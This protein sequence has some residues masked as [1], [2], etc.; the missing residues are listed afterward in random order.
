MLCASG[1]FC[2][3]RAE[4]HVDKFVS[5]FFA[6]QPE[7]DAYRERVYPRAESGRVKVFTLI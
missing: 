3:E 4:V 6:R 1:E 5:E 7:M 2:L